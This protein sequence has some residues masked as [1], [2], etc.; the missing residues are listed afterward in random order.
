MITFDSFDILVIV[1]Y[2]VLVVIIGTTRKFQNVS[3][4]DFIVA[5]RR[6]TLPAFVATIVSTFYGG[7]LGVGEFTY[8]FGI[9]SWLM[10][11]FPY[12]F[13]ILIFAI[14]FA[15]RIR[16]AEL[17]TI[18]DKLEK[19]FG[20]NVSLFA[21]FMV[22]LLTT[23]APYLL[24]I[25]LLIQLIFG[26]S[27]FWSIILTLLVSVIFLFTGGLISD[28]RV[29]IF[30][31]IMMYVGF[32][33]I[34]PFCFIEFGNPSILF[35]SLPTSH[36][37]LFGDNSIS[38]LLVWFFI[39][40][41]AIVDPAFHQRCYAA[42]S[43]EIAKRGV[44]I[45]LIFWI[46]FDTMTI[47]TG[48]YAFANIQNITNPALSYPL[49]ADK[50]LPHFAKGLFFVGLLATIMSTFHSNLLVSATTVGH[51]ILKKSLKHISPRI[52]NN[53]GLIIVTV[54]SIVI[55][56]LI[57]SVV[58]IW[59]TI[60][61]LAVP[62]LLI[63]IVPSY[64]PKMQVKNNYVFYAMIISFLVSLFSLIFGILNAQD[65]RYHYL[66]GI[67]P[68]YPGLIVGIIT[69]STGLVLKKLSVI[70]KD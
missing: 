22:V 68:I 10:N 65:G 15:K 3:E 28:I 52:L 31:F 23:P 39:G 43:P 48:L 56:V 34:I 41:W 32:G 5:G 11:A 50:I 62:P 40:S 6:V 14:F 8:R 12:Y 2:F 9:S 61:T 37:S 19:S 1:L 17:F 44:L 30:E 64:F 25:T 13:F 42:K 66:L 26:T 63:A 58:D 4:A 21:S 18:P 29:N 36:I 60:G 16:N 45:S 67:E 54:I 47:I 55:A 33:I 49:L 46:I 53:I 59:Y 35:K 70:E 7:I 24:M 51:D 20:S 38:Y 69:Y 27:M 57:P